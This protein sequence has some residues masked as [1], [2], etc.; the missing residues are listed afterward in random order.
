MKLS[1]EGRRFIQSFEGYHDALPNGGCK[2]YQRQ[3]KGKL[4]VPT[5]GWGCTEGVKP[6]MVWTRQ[7]A[8]DAFD[9]ELAKF[10]SA[11][12]RLVKVTINQHEFDACVSLSYN[13]GLGGGN[14]PGFS[15]S[16][17]LRRL[18]TGDKE[19][20]ARA[21]MMWNKVGKFEVSGLTRRRAAEAAMFLKPVEEPHGPAMPQTVNSVEDRLPPPPA[22][23]A[24]STEGQIA[25]GIKGTGLFELWQAFK[26]AWFGAKSG[27]AVHVMDLGSSLFFD[28]RF[29]IGASLVFGGLLIWLKRRQ[30]LTLWG[31]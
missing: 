12:M 13:V 11:V 1:A 15:T 23:M 21:F 20:A 9:R 28:E 14:V 16:T 17:V 5:I 27:G 7:Q 22:S 3:Y 2:A 4:D 30:K 18:N 26:D 8:E 19:G 6:G 10:E 29:W 24:Q 25:I 31:V